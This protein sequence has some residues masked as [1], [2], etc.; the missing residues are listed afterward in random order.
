[1]AAA[2]G[3]G[4]STMHVVVEVD[5][6]LGSIDA[7]LASDAEFLVRHVSRR[8]VVGAKASLVVTALPFAGF[9]HGSAQIAH[10]VWNTSWPL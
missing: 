9:A 5:P 4:D 10:Q 7:I 2:H 6:Q 8:S 1:M 3:T